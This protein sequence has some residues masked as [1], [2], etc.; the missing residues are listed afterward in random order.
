MSLD[1]SDPPSW[2]KG[3]K[4]TKY[5]ISRKSLF[6]DLF[7]MHWASAG[8]DSYGTGHRIRRFAIRCSSYTLAGTPRTHHAVFYLDLVLGIA[9]SPRDWVDWVLD[10]DATGLLYCL[11]FG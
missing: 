4:E 5:D 1:V 8:C 10:N 3:R 6:C 11:P 2:R 9:M 7:L